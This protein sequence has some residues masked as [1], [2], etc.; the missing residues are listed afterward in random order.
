MYHRL[1]KVVSW[2]HYDAINYNFFLSKMSFLLKVLTIPFFD[3]I[4]ILL[5]HMYQ[6]R[7]FYV[8]LTLFIYI[9]HNDTNDNKLRN[10]IPIPECTN[11]CRSSELCELNTLPQIVHVFTA[12]LVLCD[13]MW[14][15]SSFFEGRVILQTGQMNFSPSGVETGTIWMVKG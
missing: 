6:T 8:F 3:S 2:V 13:R 1:L 4:C 15:V 14:A 5:I 12:E 11:M 9:Y 10:Q 7:I